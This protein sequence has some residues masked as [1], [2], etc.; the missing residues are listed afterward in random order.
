MLT[1]LK[2]KEI[3]MLDINELLEMKYET[4][5]DCSNKDFKEGKSIFLKW[6]VTKKHLSEFSNQYEYLE[7]L[8]ELYGEDELA[9]F[10]FECEESSENNTAHTVSYDFMNFVSGMEAYVACIVQSNNLKKKLLAS[11]LK[12]A[13]TEGRNIRSCIRDYVDAASN[14]GIN[15]RVCIDSDGNIDYESTLS[16]FS[17]LPISQDINFFFYLLK[18]NDFEIQIDLDS[19]GSIYYENPKIDDKTSFSREVFDAQYIHECE[20]Q[21]KYV[22]MSKEQ[23]D[24]SLNE[25]K[26]KDK[27]LTKLEEE[28]ENLSKQE[29]FIKRF[30]KV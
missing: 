23:E 6:L 29:I 26:A 8:I 25:L 22:Q 5:D 2:E 17:M 20:Y 11:A 18:H 21:P 9:N 28:Q 16:N 19:L 27:E 14:H 13:E 30:E 12:T 1:Y 4:L 3:F 7:H 10:S 24:K 15:D